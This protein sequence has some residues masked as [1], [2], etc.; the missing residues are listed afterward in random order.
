MPIKI[1]TLKNNIDGRSLGAKI[2][3]DTNP[4]LPGMVI[5]RMT[6][7]DLFPPIHRFG[8]VSVPGR[9]L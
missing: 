9:V 2:L 7:P 3:P 8:M 1:M 5:R 4:R 6:S